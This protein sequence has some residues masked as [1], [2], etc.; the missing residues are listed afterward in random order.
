ML[1]SAG[2]DIKHYTTT[3]IRLFEFYLTVYFSGPLSIYQTHQRESQITFLIY[4][5]R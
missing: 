5:Y 1:F 4:Q 2:F 3:E